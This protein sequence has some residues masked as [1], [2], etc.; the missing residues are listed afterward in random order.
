MTTRIANSPGHDANVARSVQGMLVARYADRAS[1]VEIQ[2]SC[3][4]VRLQAR[5]AIDGLASRHLADDM[6]GVGA[7]LDLRA[8]PQPRRER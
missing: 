7:P 6:R 1:T 4:W 3:D 5:E 8:R 2:V